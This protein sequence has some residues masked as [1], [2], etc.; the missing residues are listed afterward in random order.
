MRFAFYAN[1]IVE[2]LGRSISYYSAIMFSFE[3]NGDIQGQ[4]SS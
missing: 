2:I 4:T 1:M 3:L